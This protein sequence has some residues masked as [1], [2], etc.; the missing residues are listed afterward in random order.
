MMPMRLARGYCAVGGVVGGKML[1]RVARGD[2]VSRILH[3]PRDTIAFIADSIDRDRRAVCCSRALSHL[4][5]DK[6]TIDTCLLTGRT[7]KEVTLGW[8]F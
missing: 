7:G 3:V 2:R 6:S 5:D 1:N 4:S 8:K